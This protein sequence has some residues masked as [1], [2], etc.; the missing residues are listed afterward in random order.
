MDNNLHLVE[1]SRSGDQEAFARIVTQY[2]GMVSAVTLNVVGD[3]T[4]SEDLAQETFLT[5]WKKL[6][7]LREPEKLAS[8]IYGIAKRTALN[9]TQKQ[10]R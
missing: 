4:Q 1:R 3:Y 9:W 10:Q 8:W 7:D 5:V 2:K 6:A